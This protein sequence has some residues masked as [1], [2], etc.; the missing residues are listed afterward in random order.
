LG[1]IALTISRYASILSTTIAVSTLVIL[2]IFALL[3]YTP[4]A[5]V[6]FGVL[7]LIAIVA[8]LRPNYARLRAGTERKIGKQIDN[9][10]KVSPQ[11]D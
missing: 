10:V 3:G 9:I 6:A 7:N 5:Y 4:Y 2:I 1:L 8:A 11:R